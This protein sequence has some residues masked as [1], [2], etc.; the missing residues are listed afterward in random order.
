MAPGVLSE[1]PRKE[2]GEKERAGR[3]RHGCGPCGGHERHTRGKSSCA[4][5][6]PHKLGDRIFNCA[7]SLIT[8]P[9]VPC[10]VR[11]TRFVQND[12]LFC[13]IPYTP[14]APRAAPRCG[15]LQ[16]YRVQKRY[17]YEMK[18]RPRRRD[19][20]RPCTRL[21]PGA[22]PTRRFAPRAHSAHVTDGAPDVK[23][24]CSRRLEGT[25]EHRSASAHGM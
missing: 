22:H 18:E 8:I 3:P 24:R 1:T 10:C 11:H 7:G 23:T 9:R 21:S 12:V 6:S 15:G 25:H 13:I 2:R 5:A 16:F 20:H 14:T 4:T 19:R 17:I